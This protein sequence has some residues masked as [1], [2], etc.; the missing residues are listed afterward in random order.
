[1]SVITDSL[2]A[3]DQVSMTIQSAEIDLAATSTGTIVIPAR[4]GWYFLLFTVRF[5]HTTTSGTA[6]TAPT[7]KIGNSV[8]IDNMVPSA[9][10]PATSAHLA[11]APNL[12]TLS[13]ASQPK[14]VDLATPVTC[15]VTTAATGTGGFAWKVRIELQ[16]VYVPIP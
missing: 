1:M 12:S 9:S 11:G 15:S 6:S 16:G 4:P 3:G 7:L 8:T 14:P 2:S 5:F 10:A 13:P